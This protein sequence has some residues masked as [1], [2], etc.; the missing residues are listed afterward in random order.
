MQTLRAPD[1]LGSENRAPSDPQ[2]LD[3]FCRAAVEYA[4]G[5]ELGWLV[6]LPRDGGEPLVRGKVGLPGAMGV[7][8][9]MI[10]VLVPVPSA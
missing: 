4:G 2:P 1:E 7:S 3:Y 5:P 6:F 10:R 9:V 8:F